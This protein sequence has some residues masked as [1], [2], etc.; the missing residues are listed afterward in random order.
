[1]SGY[2]PTFFILQELVPPDVFEERGEYAWE[3]LDMRA[4][5]TLVSLRTQFGP[6]TVNSWHEGGRYHDSGYR[7]PNSKVGVPWS[8]HRYGRAFDCKF[9]LATPQEVYAYVY[10]NTH[11]FPMLTTLEDVA[12]TPTW[13]HFDT[14]LNAISGIRIVR[15]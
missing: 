5:M 12:T 14:R 11:L 1:M 2:R 9:A 3:L 4:L 7:S 10:S 13:L 15:P 8:Q 6:L